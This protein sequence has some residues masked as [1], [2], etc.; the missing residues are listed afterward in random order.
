MSRDLDRK[1]GEPPLEGLEMLT[2]QDRRRRQHRHLLAFEDGLERGA[3]GD[4]GLAVADIADDET[5]HGRGLLQV[6]L[7]VD[8]GA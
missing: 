2:D 1:P 4:L 3:N 6:G 8:G 5:V 7:D